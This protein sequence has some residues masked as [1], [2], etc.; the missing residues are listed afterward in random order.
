MLYSHSEKVQSLAGYALALFSF[1]SVLQQKKIAD[2]GG[3]RWENF[4][5]F[6]SSDDDYLAISAAFQVNYYQ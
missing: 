6:L 5:P 1:N 4:A 3:V 2:C